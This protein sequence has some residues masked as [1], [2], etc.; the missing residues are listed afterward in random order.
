MAQITSFETLKTYAS[1]DVVTLPAFSEDQPFV[2]RLRRPSM[3]KLVKSGR[4]PNAL[5]NKANELFTSGIS[6]AF[7]EENQQALS[8]M[9]DLMDTICEASFIEPTWQEIQESGIDLTDEQL[10][11]VFNYSQAGVKALESF[12]GESENPANIGI[13]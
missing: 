2:A 1:G 11:F 8:Q 7:D 6:G 3:M 12:R 13:E 4:I 9:F 5:L 10:M